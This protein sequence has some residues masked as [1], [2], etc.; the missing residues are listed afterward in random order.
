MGLV[1]NLA[2]DLIQRHGD[3]FTAD[4]EQNKKLLEKYVQFNSKSLRNKVA[5]HITSYVNKKMA[6]SKG[7]EEEKP[8]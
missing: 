1:K 5:G 3:E 6:A 4:F 8:K 2:L 7:E